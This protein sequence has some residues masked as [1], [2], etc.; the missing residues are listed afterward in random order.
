MKEFW[1]SIQLVFAAIGECS[2]LG[3]YGV[4]QHQVLATA[5]Q[6]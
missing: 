5:G 6:G 1:N 3:R 2:L 4:C